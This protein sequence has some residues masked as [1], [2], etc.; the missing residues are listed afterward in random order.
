MDCEERKY[1]ERGREESVARMKREND[2]D[3]EEK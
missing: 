2:S 3:W 1:I